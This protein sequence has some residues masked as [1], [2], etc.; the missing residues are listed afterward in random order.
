MSWTVI[1]VANNKFIVSML[2]SVVPEV[3][4][5]AGDFIDYFA[6]LDA[7]VD[8]AN[9]FK[10]I[11]DDILAIAECLAWIDGDSSDYNGQ[12]LV[13]IFFGDR[14]KNKKKEFLSKKSKM[15]K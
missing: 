12:E 15:I 11:Q 13:K 4:D 14:Y 5:M 10:K 1:D 8:D 6:L 3:L 7:Y 9:F 2:K